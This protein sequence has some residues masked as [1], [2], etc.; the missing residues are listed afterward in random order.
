MGEMFTIN[1]MARSCSEL[2]MRLFMNFPSSTQRGSVES[3][4]KK[5]KVVLNKFFNKTEK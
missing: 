1:P 4:F 2:P 5:W 3:F